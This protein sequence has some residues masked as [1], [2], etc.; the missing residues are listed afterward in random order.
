LG[1]PF[2][3]CVSF[4]FFPSLAAFQG[5][6]LVGLPGTRRL[7][8]RYLPLAPSP[9]FPSFPPYSLIFPQASFQFF[10]ARGRASAVPPLETQKP[11]VPLFSPSSPL[12]APVQIR[13]RTSNNLS[14]PP[15]FRHRFLYNTS[16]F[17]RYRFSQF[18]FVLLSFFLPFLFPSPSTRMP[19]LPLL[20]CPL[21]GR[22]LF[23]PPPVSTSPFQCLVLP[24]P[25]AATPL[26]RTP[27]RS[28]FL[29][30]FFPAFFLIT[31]SL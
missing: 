25:C 19:L 28:P 14:P 26:P 11:S 27:S 16:P 6:C 15:L 7:F 9:F 22:S 1:C 31:L 21:F 3:P 8:S 13:F 5:V 12:P 10:A 30:A 29:P 17:P 2:S 24:H 20:V 18:F 23:S 4:F